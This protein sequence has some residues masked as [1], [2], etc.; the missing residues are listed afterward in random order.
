VQAGSYL[1]AYQLRRGQDDTGD[2]DNLGNP[3][4]FANVV[5]S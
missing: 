1:L 5:V 4:W 2:F 3:A